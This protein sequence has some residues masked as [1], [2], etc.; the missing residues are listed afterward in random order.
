VPVIASGFWAG[1]AASGIDGYAD[2]SVIETTV[3]SDKRMYAEIWIKNGSYSSLK[4]H[5][6]ALGSETLSHR[7]KDLES[8]QYN[9]PISRKF[10]IAM[11][12]VAR[13]R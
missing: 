10:Q 13:R 1:G 3:A 9:V 6:G 5:D 2:I 12:T 11:V 4:R 7:F 8:G